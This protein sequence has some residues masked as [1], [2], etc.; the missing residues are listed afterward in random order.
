[1]RIDKKEQTENIGLI[2]K[3]EAAKFKSENRIMLSVYG[4]FLIHGSMASTCSKNVG[5]KTSRYFR[6]R[7]ASDFRD[8]ITYCQSHSLSLFYD[9]QGIMIKSGKKRGIIGMIKSKRMDRL[10]KE[11]NVCFMRNGILV[12]EDV[13]RDYAKMVNTSNMLNHIVGVYSE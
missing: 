6:T 12:E 5:I 8:I 2:T 1:M 11:I 4:E 10:S 7:S 3:E 9:A 13:L